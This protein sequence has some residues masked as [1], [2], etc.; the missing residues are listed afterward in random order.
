MMLFVCRSGLALQCSLCFEREFAGDAALA[1]FLGRYA[2]I[3]LTVSLVLQLFVV[4]R[5]VAWLGLRGAH[6]VYAVIFASAALSGWGEM[7]LAAAVWARFVEGDLRYGL[8]N[9]LAQ[10]TVNYFPK[11]VRTQVRAWS[12][13]FLIPSAT[14][15]ASLVLD[16]ILRAGSLRGV[17]IV[18]VAAGAAYLGASLGLAS[19]IP[20]AP[21]ELRQNACGSR[22]GARFRSGRWA[23]LITSL[24]TRSN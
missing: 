10:M 12:L 24:P 13:G 18:T 11:P 8:R 19:A 20:L 14:L 17:A 4:N 2:Q 21:R 16:A 15:A 6:L 7:T 9:P 1:Q 23:S 22:T 3:A 5:L